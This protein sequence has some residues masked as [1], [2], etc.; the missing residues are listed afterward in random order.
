MPKGGEVPRIDRLQSEG[1][2]LLTM[3]QVSYADHLIRY[4]LDIG[5]SDTGISW[6]DINQWQKAVDLKIS[7]WEAATIKGLAKSYLL[8]YNKSMN[9]DCPAPYIDLKACRKNIDKKIR[10]V[11]G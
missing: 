3:P 8:Q 4:M 11:F 6:L 9:S 2:G 5:I 7:P 10:S 1:S